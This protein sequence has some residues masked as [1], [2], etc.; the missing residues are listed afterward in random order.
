MGYYPYIAK[1]KNGHE[2]DAAFC[3]VEPMYD[4]G[5]GDCPECD[6]REFTKDYGSN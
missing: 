2:W 6:T 4:S 1:C 5:L 3:S